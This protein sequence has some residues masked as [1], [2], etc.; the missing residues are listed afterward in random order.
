MKISNM[1]EPVSRVKQGTTD[2]K[3]IKKK[4]KNGSRG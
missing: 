2:D 4:K 3:K 1:D